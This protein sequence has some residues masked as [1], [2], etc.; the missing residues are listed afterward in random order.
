MLYKSARK[1][2]MLRLLVEE[3]LYLM[4]AVVRAYAKRQ[5][6]NQRVVQGGGLISAVDGRLKVSQRV[7]KEAEKAGRAATRAV[8]KQAKEDAT[9]HAEA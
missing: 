1:N 4:Q 9:Q 2:T 8:K 7:Q 5:R 6:T 3:D